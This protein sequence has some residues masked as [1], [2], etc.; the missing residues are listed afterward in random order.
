LVFIWR[1]REEEGLA[2]V[3]TKHAVLGLMIERPTY[4]Y[5]IQSQATDLLSCLDL[6]ESGAYKVL[7]RLEEMGWIEVVGEQEGTS[8]RGPKRIL[9]RAT[10]E[11]VQEFENWIASPAAKPQMRDEL[12]AR[13]A[14]SRAQDRPE[15][16]KAAEAQLRAAWT[17]LAAM[18]H[19]APTT[20]EQAL[21]RPW[22]MTVGAL[23]IDLEARMLRARIDWLHHL[24]ELLEALQDPDV[25][26]RSS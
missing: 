2:K 24:C 5:R 3:S 6:S 16:L 26:T 23:R 1:W 10:G 13:L 4:G 18:R 12:Q 17:E 11:G 9:F 15:V 8:P 7:Q 19:P 20:L 14:V 21:E 25:N 22:A